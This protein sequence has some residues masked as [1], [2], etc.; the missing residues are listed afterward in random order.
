MAKKK[1]KEFYTY[2]EHLGTAM[3]MPPAGAPPVP[4]VAPRRR[5]MEESE[6]SLPTAPPSAPPVPV[7]Q[8]NEPPQLPPLDIG[9]HHGHH[10]QH[11][12][13]PV[14]DDVIE[15]ELGDDERTE[16][17][18]TNRRSVSGIGDNSSSK[19]RHSYV[20]GSGS[21]PPIPTS[22]TSPTAAQQQMK[23]A[24]TFGSPTSSRGVG[25]ESV[26][27]EPMSPSRAPP[28]PPPSAASAPQQPPPAH[29]TM[30]PRPPL[31]ER[32]F[33]DSGITTGYDADEDTDLNA[34]ASFD[35]EA[36]PS[37]RMSGSGQP[38]RPPPPPPPAAAPPHPVGQSGEDED[39][40]DD[41]YE[42]SDTTEDEQPSSAA[43][44]QPTRAAPP[45]PP[46]SAGQAPLH[47]S[48]TGA[49]RSSMDTG[50]NSTNISRAS[51]DLSRAGR[52]SI[53]GGMVARD[54][55][56][57]LSTE[58]WTRPDGVPSAVANNR[59]DLIYEV[60][61]STTPKRGGR[62][63]V[64]RDIYIVY[65]DYSQTV[66]TAR[67]EQH[68]PVNTL[69]IEQEHTPA[70][71]LRQDQLEDFYRKFGP[72]VLDTAQKLSTQTFSSQG[73]FVPAVLK[74]VPGVLP[75]VG[76]RAF[77]API[78]T[79]LANASVRQFDE[80]RPGDI[81]AFRN[82]KFQGHK[83]GLHQKYSTEAGRGDTIHVGIVYEWDGTKKKVRVYEQ[84]QEK[85]NKVRQ[86]GYRLNDLKSGEVKAYRV[87]GRNYVG[88]D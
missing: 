14:R 45:P 77:G 46:P 60:E 10:H 4:P 6:A 24:S 61:D 26:E 18:D 71:S 68:D 69:S 15:D 20:G 8:S 17:D 1:K 63:L 76:T 29:P 41:A 88:W 54:I 36:A 51:T 62:T 66:L 86:E 3:G 55:D 70:P 40:K 5:S 33:S 13:H 85:A 67:Y 44:Q 82:A 80:I 30:A 11:V 27:E 57:E 84:H 75:P 73:E 35:E 22:A 59:R 34:T 52:S 2:N 37:K 56:P 64:V 21:I 78:Y 87:V 49:S 83:G 79:N 38:N 16:S 72:V 23:R 9:G 58:W 53:E 31:H 25:S 48:S 74:Q 65:H 43:E 42:E 32:E 7:K 81:V 50:R 47:R 12:P 28:P 19:K 39:L